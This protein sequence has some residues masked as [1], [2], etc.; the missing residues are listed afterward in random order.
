MNPEAK[1]VAAIERAMVDIR[2]LQTRRTLARIST[3]RSE[4]RVDPTLTAV[5]DALESHTGTPCTVS[6]IATALGVD[7]PRASR[8]VARAVEAG[9]V[10]RT[11]DQ[12]D[13]RRTLLTLTRA[14]TQH[15]EAVH[16]FRR[17]L[18][19]EALAGWSPRQ[20]A[21]FARLLTRFVNSYTELATD[22][23]DTPRHTDQH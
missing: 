14:G 12:L 16:H 15:A 8:L 3:Q 19:A 22:D 2:R 7:Q 5:V 10:T 23:A 11:A 1:D 9:L 21:T 13:A 17:A 20:T 4:A 18:F 6:T